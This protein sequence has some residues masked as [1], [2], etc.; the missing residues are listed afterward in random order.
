LTSWLPVGAPT[1]QLTTLQPIGTGPEYF[2]V[3][4]Q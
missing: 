3:V 1:E 4:G 2:R